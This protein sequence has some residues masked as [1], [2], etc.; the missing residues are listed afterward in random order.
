MSYGALS[1][2]AVLAL[3]MGARKAGIWMN[4]GEGGLA[5]W[6]LQGGCDLVFQIGTAK[7]MTASW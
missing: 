5:P 7:W 6:H 4:T 1:K 2:P 3:S